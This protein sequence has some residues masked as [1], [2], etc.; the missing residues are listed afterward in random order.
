M[1]PK[2]LRAQL[3]MRRWISLRR[4]PSVMSYLLQ[5]TDF[6]AY[7]LLKSETPATPLVAKYRLDAA[8]ER[9]RPVIVKE[10]S[11]KDPRGLGIVRT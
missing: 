9:L 3:S 10:A 8:Y 7:A 1:I 5:L 6:I 11:R 2:G 4:C